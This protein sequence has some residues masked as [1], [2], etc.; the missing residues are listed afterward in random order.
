MKTPKNKRTFCPKCKAQT[1][2]TVAL[3]KTRE[4]GTL[5]KGSIAR[6]TKRG[7]AKA[8]FGNHGKF[9][10]KATA[11]RKR[12]GAKTSKKSDFRLTCLTCK[13]TQVKSSGTR[14]KKLTIEERT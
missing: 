2:H 7:S 11:G 8:G 12:T 5:K 4:R 9:S 1:D 3:A 10:R 14:A 13:K 6:L